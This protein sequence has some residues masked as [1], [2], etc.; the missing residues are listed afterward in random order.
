MQD[1]MS[2]QD[3]P[4]DDDESF[5]SAKSQH[6]DHDHDEKPSNPTTEPETHTTAT[7]FS[8]EEERVR[9]Q[10]FALASTPPTTTTPR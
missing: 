9:D 8:P 1:N 7:K 2:R 5:T 10:S 3:Y 6:D 4:S